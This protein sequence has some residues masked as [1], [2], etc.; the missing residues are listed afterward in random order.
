MTTDWLDELRQLHE[1][2]KQ[3]HE[4]EA[5]A[6][7]LSVLRRSEQAADLLSKCQAYRL[8][9]RAQQALLAGKGQID[10]SEHT[11]KYE[12]VIT[13]V[14]QG[15]ISNAR[16]PDLNDPEDYQYV[17]VGTRGG[18]VY[19]NEQVLEPVTPEALKVALIK[20]S[21]KPA[22]QQPAKWFESMRKK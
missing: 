22:R 21:K 7:D 19:V 6:L 14:W 16:M 5:R 1:A 3:K 13:L 4:E 15:P 17:A 2:D 12:R 10:I 18:K 20:A 9:R 11:E 8:L